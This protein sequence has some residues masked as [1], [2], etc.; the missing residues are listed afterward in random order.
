MGS[1]S[2]E[3][4]GK[5]R[6]IFLHPMSL[7]QNC[8]SVFVPLIDI[9]VMI[10]TLVCVNRP[11]L[12][13]DGPA[14]YVIVTSIRYKIQTYKLFK[15]KSSFNRT[16]QNIVFGHIKLAILFVCSF[17]FVCLDLALECSSHPCVT[18]F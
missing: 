5:S 16:I 17:Y 4:L 3:L 13:C 8:H 18:Y 15:K 11:S 7:A 10:W 14:P 2:N 9:C 12:L 6:T 1:V